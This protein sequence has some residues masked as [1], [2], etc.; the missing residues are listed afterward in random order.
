M[1]VKELMSDVMRRLAPEHEEARSGLA[2]APAG[3]FGSRRE[4]LYGYARNPC[5]RTSCPGQSSVPMRMRLLKKRWRCY[6]NAGYGAWPS[7]GKA[8]SSASSPAPICSGP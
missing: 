1:N 2:C 6:R 3:K 8:V 5:G 4:P 7:S